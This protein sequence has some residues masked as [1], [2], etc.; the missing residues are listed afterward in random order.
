LFCYNYSD[1]PKEVG[2]KGKV[3]ILSMEKEVLH[4]FHSNFGQEL[5]LNFW[6]GEMPK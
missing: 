1:K 2:I 5:L 3:Q 4:K 6:V